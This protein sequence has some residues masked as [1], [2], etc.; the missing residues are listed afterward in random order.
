[1]LAPSA[2]T[3]R[4]SATAV[5]QTEQTTHGRSHDDRKK[6]V[7]LK[8][9]RWWSLIFVVVLFILRAIPLITDPA[10]IMVDV[11]ATLA[12]KTFGLKLLDYLMRK[13]VKKK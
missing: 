5:A 11:L 9:K 1:M 8:L 12:L 10:G 4:R 3:V 2:T 13:V 7:F 6:D